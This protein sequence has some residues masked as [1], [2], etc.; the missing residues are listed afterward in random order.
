MDSFLAD[1]LRTSP[2]AEVLADYRDDPSAP[3]DDHMALRSAR[4]VLPTES[5]TD[6][7]NATLVDQSESARGE[8]AAAWGAHDNLTEGA[9]KRI[10]E[11][12][13]ERNPEARRRCIEH[14]GA[15]CYIC[16]F[17][18]ART[19]GSV[20][21]G[22][23]HVHHLRALSEIGVEYVVDPIADLRPLCPNCHAVVHARDPQY[24]ME[25]VRALIVKARTD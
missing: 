16:E 13:Y 4:S 23:I 12:E 15:L 1:H 8:D 10:F 21:L 14:Y 17:E 19:Y 22:Y 9:V 24:T 20:V 2:D 5:E 7:T 18:F 11:N 3:S 6:V 25:E